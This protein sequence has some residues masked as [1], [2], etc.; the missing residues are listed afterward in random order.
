MIELRK[1]PRQTRAQATVD[2]LIEAAA[3]IL[4]RGG[5]ASL[6]TNL[7][8][9]RAGASIGSLYQ[10]F[11]S[12]E[13]LLVALIR[14]DRARL[15]AAVAAACTVPGT[16]AESLEALIQAAVAHQLDRPGLARA[17]DYAEPTLPLDP[18]TEALTVRLIQAIAG[19]FA[20]HGIAEPV[21]AARDLVALCKGMVDAAGRAGETDREALAARVAR[22]AAG[23]LGPR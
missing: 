12:K 9:E 2:A 7:V 20:R 6:T 23:Y 10:Y 13:A 8:A 19:L 1:T 21:T 4:D 22:A 16:F 18:E 3:H 15:E 5:L 17:L 14:Q 11:P